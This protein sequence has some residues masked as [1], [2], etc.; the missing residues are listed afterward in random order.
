[1]NDDY[2]KRKYYKY[3]LKYL[4]LKGGKITWNPKTWFG[5]PQK[6]KAERKYEALQIEQDRQREE[7]ERHIREL[8]KL[9]LK[10]TATIPT[11]GAEHQREIKRQKMRQKIDDMLQCLKNT[12]AYQE[13][14]RN[15]NPLREM[16]RS[17]QGEVGAHLKELNKARKDHNTDRYNELY[18]NPPVKSNKMIKLEDEQIQNFKK[19]YKK[20][21]TNSSLTKDVENLLSKDLTNDIMHR[22]VILGILS[23]VG[24]ER[25]V[26]DPVEM[27][28]RLVV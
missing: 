20:C 26:N 27:V 21:L 18:N 12:T 16:I 22:D 17:F 28:N 24:S 8:K 1:M 6:D 25:N 10:R 5:V 13:L 11:Y 15:Y 14:G 19:V 7:E 3:K 2:Y 23:N 4:K 9:G